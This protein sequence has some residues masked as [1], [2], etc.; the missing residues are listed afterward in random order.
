MQNQ[1]PRLLVV[2]DDRAILTLIGTIALAEGFDVATTINGEEAMKQLRQR[3]AELVLLDLRMPGV[4]GLDVLRSIR[5]VSP[6]LQGRPDDRLRDHRQR[7]GSGQARRAA[8]TSPSRSTCSGCGS[9]SRRSATKLERRGAVL[10]ARRRAGAAPR[11]LRH[12]RPR[13]GDAGGVRP[14]PAAG[15]ARR[16][17][18]SITGETG[19]GKELVA[20]ALH[21]LGPRSAKRFVTV[22]CSAVVETLFESELFGH[23]RGAFTGATDHKAGAVRDR[24]RR[25]AVPRRDRRAAA[26]GAGEAAARAR[27]GRS[28][29]R[30]LARA[31][32][33]RRPA[34]SRRPT[35]T[36][37]PKSPP[38]ASAATSTTA[39]TSSRSRCRRCASAARTSRT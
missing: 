24:R 36:C 7:G 14:D 9:C 28:A 20:R 3:P 1:R 34:R 16:A 23:V 32:Q 13:S 26:A 15:A 10:D 25:H 35:A 18:R 6:K 19:T 12:G 8:T 39:S 29:A 17:P 38:A 37:S 31:A 22:N 2:D 21:K 5:D 11:V 4:T 30:G 27:G 33:G